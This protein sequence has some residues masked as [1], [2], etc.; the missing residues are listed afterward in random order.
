MT[1]AQKDAIVKAAQ[2]L[3]DVVPTAIAFMDKYGPCTFQVDAL[4]FGSVLCAV[5]AAEVPPPRW[6]VNYSFPS[7]KPILCYDGV[8]QRL[9]RLDNDALSNLA[10]L[11]NEDDAK[12]GK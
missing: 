7:G 2:A 5:R 3:V 11:L 1:D 8:E 4:K 9:D 12:G 6:S 10:R